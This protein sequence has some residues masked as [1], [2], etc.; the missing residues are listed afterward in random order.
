MILAV[1]IG[2][3]KT[4]LGLVEGTEVRARASALTDAQPALTAAWDGLCQTLSETPRLDGVIVCSVVPEAT[5][6]VMEAARA[7]TG[8]E[9]VEYTAATPI[10][11]TVRYEPPSDV[12]ADRLVNAYAAWQLHGLPAI[13][14]DIGTAL[15]IDCINAEAEYLGGVIAPGIGISLD[16]L[17]TRTALLPK[18]ELQ[19][20]PRV[21]GVSTISS[22]QS[23][24][25]HGHMLMI[26]GLVAK[27]REELG[28][29]QETQIIITGGYTVILAPRLLE[30]SSL[31]D[32]D[33]TLRG[34]ALIDKRIRPPR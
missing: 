18:V 12:G 13:I 11:I 10:G 15:T 5:P 31:I 28:F 9:P 19:P 34:L 32:P 17:H 14:A 20:P 8:L 4:A 21:L 2:N 6:S 7:L 30:I 26:A 25:T 27:L 22:I 16:A 29:G 24:V 23:G 1:D 3:T 33:L